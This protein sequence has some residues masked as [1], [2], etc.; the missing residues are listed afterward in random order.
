[1]DENEC[2]EKG[3]GVTS[4]R[5]VLHSQLVC[6]LLSHVNNYKTSKAWIASLVNE[7]KTGS[8]TQKEWLYELYENCE[9]IDYYIDDE[10]ML[11]LIDD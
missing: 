6:S 2:K 9:V 7:L 11:N 10:T 8:S 4:F 5:Y 1:M 3:W